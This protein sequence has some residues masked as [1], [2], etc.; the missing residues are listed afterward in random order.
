MVDQIIVKSLEEALMYLN[1]KPFLL[2]AGGTDLMIQNR[3]VSETPVDFKKDILYISNLSECKYVKFDNENV[4]IGSLTSL[5]TLS[6]HEFVPQ[7]LKDTIHEMASPGIRNVATI[8]GN[9]GNASPAGD[10]LVT[11]YLLDASVK[12]ESLHQKRIIPIE[13]FIT[14]VRKTLLKDN[15]LITEIIIPKKS[16]SFTS[17][18]KVGGRKADAISKVSF[19]GAYTVENGIV[20]DFRIALGAIYQTVLRRKELEKEYTGLSVCTIRSKREE[21]ISRYTPFIQ[22]IDDQRSNKKYRL[23]VAKNMIGAFIDSM[24]LI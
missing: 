7:L 21:I 14:G 19:A 22:P 16:F 15:E 12:V 1:E 9:I 23:Q 24:K 6:H 2:L 20:T 11:L 3:A 13:N 5:E 17:F 18:V 4:Y 8:A 10:S